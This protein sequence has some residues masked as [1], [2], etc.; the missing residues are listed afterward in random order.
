[1]PLT[2]RILQRKFSAGFIIRSQAMKNLLANQR[3]FYWRLPTIAAGIYLLWRLEPAHAGL[4]LVGVIF[5]IG[6]MLET[7][8]KLL[9]E[10][11]CARGAMTKIQNQVSGGAITAAIV[12]GE[13]KYLS[14][15]LEILRDQL[16]N[17]LTKYAAS[18]KLTTERQHRELVDKISDTTAA[19]TI[20]HV[21]PKAS[22][23]EHA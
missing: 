10:I 22:Q 23:H 12:D 21:T 20:P 6:L 4:F 15:E 16:S 3:K 17:F 13:K 14:Q 2:G 8:Q 1:M 9:R 5:V 19:T 11:R 18:Q 7:R